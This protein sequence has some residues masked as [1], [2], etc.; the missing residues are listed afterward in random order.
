MS[1]APCWLQAFFRPRTLF[2]EAFAFIAPIQPENPALW[3]ST[4]LRMRSARDSRGFNRLNVAQ[5]RR[6]PEV[7]ESEPGTNLQ[8]PAFAGMTNV[9]SPGACFSECIEEARDFKPLRMKR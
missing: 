2:P 1:G 6:K 3:L 4:V 9:A 8:A 5:R 7:F